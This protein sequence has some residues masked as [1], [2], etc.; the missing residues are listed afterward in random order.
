MTSNGVSIRDRRIGELAPARAIALL[1]GQ[2]PPLARAD[3]SPASGARLQFQ[4]ILKSLA[5]SAPR[6]GDA[7][8]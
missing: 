5:A 8:R 1:G 2:G 3:F 4:T 6:P 7:A